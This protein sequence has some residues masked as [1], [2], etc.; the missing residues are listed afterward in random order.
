MVHVVIVAVRSEID[1]TVEEGPEMVM[2]VMI[3]GMG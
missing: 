1:P 3:Y 2:V